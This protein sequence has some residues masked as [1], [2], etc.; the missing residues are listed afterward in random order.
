V[1]W[2]AWQV[3]DEAIAQL[4]ELGFDTR[5][6]RRALRFAGGELASAVT[7][8][9]QQRERKQVSRVGSM[10]RQW[11]Q[12]QQQQQWKRQRKQQLCWRRQQL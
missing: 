7:F 12:Q 6:S 5:E 9:T 4:Q 3:P 10:H 2:L 1:H 11:Q 8:I